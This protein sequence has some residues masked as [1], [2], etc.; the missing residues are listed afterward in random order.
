MGKPPT[1][2]NALNRVEPVTPLGCG[3]LEPLSYILLCQGNSCQTLL[4]PLIRSSPPLV[5]TDLNSECLF[6]SSTNGKRTCSQHLSFCVWLIS[7]NITPSSYSHF[8]ASIKIFFLSSWHIHT[9]YYHN[10][11]SQVTQERFLIKYE[12]RASAA[13]RWQGAL[14]TKPV[15]CWGRQGIYTGFQQQKSLH[16]LLNSMSG[17]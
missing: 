13:G 7:S 3:T 15:Q 8:T 12:E 17:V 10:S 9:R 6:L 14:R 1:N 11:S 16:S 5:I 4:C 2:P